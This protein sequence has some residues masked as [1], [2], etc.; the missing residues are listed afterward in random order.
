MEFE[1]QAELVQVGVNEA[2]SSLYL[3]FSQNWE[4]L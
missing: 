1:R 3:T 2:G 4:P